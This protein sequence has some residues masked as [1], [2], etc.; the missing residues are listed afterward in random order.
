MRVPTGRGGFGI[1]RVSPVVWLAAAATWTAAVALRAG[2]V[3]DTPAVSTRAGVYSADQAQRGQALFETT[4][5]G[6]C[7][8]AA[9]HR[10]PVFKGHWDG[11]TLF[12]LFEII[13][14]T[15]PDD[16]PGSLSPKQSA[17]IVAYLLKLNGQPAGT[18]D[19][20]IEPAALKKIRIELAA[21]SE[22]RRMER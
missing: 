20:P 22:V 10:G 21:G 2:A 4:C 5:L 6:G 8:N 17:E 15:M 13:N 18:G 19:L 12:D 9:S 1:V 7:H 14:D 16:D 3:Q 11:R